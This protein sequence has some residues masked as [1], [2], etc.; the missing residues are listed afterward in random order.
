MT[1]DRIGAADAARF[2]LLNRVFPDDRFREE[3]MS[4]ARRLARGP[5]RALARIKQ[6]TYT[7]AAGTL[8]DAFKAE[9]D[10]QE[11]LFLA[12]DAREG[13]QAFLEKRDPK[14]L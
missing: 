6:A 2:G 3:V 11:D 7:A 14:F 4:F 12:A 5:A 9:A 10:A 13:M 8:R 1:G